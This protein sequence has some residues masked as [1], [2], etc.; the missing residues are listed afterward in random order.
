MTN[1]GMVI[2]SD[3]TFSLSSTIVIR[4]S[5]SDSSMIIC[6]VIRISINSSIRNPT[7]QQA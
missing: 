7:N 3:P 4:I 5:S 1:Y 2:M 6:P